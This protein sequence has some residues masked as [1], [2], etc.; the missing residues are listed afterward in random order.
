MVFNQFDKTN[1]P[2]SGSECKWKVYGQNVFFFCNCNMKMHYSR[3][4]LYLV[5][6]LSNFVALQSN[7]FFKHVGELRYHLY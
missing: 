3:P 5:L 7:L 4:A 2:R 6:G 1:K